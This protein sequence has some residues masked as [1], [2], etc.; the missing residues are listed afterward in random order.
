MARIAG[1]VPDGPNPG[2]PYSASVRIGSLVAAA[3]QCGYLPDRS[4]VEGLTAQT[5]LAMQNLRDALQASGAGLDDVI[6]VDA[7]L[8]D[9]D[10]FAEFNS[11]YA[12]F[13]TEPYPARTTIYCGLRPGVLVEVKALAVS[14]SEQ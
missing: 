8:T 6:S 3:G 9:T 11:V 7:Y 4:L 12:E 5:R 14:S 1:V 10:D 2:G 13:F